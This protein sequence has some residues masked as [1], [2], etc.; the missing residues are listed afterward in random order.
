MDRLFS[1]G[2]ALKVEARRGEV[3][4]CE[5]TG[6]RRGAAA[7]ELILSESESVMGSQCN[8]GPTRR[9]SSPHLL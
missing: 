6:C 5:D 9:G 8:R 1:N 4:D 2:F 3:Q 7:D